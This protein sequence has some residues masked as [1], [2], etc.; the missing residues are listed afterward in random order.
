VISNAAMISFKAPVSH[1]LAQWNGFFSVFPSFLLSSTQA[2]GNAISWWNM[3]LS[4]DNT[5]TYS[6]GQME[7]AL[8]MYWVIAIFKN[9]WATK[10]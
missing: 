4:L 8:P 3:L 2:A 9:P 6:F 5:N 10:G 7:L 1:V